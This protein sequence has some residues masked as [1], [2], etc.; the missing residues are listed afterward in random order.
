MLMSPFAKTN[1]KIEGILWVGYPGQAGGDA[2]AQI[3]FGDYNPGNFLTYD[4][5]KLLYKKLRLIA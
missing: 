2:I 3:I 1:S 5:L 4:Q